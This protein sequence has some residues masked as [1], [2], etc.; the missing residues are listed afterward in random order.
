MTAAAIEKVQPHLPETGPSPAALRV[1]RP[2]I[3]LRVC[4]KNY[5]CV[6][7]CPRNAISVGQKGWPVVNYGLCDGCLICLRECPTSAITEE[8]G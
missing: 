6:V 1:I 8:R 2:K 4:G 3:D 7:F 5:H